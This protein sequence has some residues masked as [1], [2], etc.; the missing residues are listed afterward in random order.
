M[1]RSYGYAPNQ[2]YGWDTTSPD[3]H[4]HISRIEKM[5]S[6]LTDVPQYPQY[7]NV[8]KAFKNNY[9]SGEE[10]QQQPPKS[11]KSSPKANKKVQLSDHAEIVESNIS[12]ENCEVQKETIDTEAD[13][14]IQKKR[15][16]F[17]LCK[18]KSFKLH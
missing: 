13:G 4:A 17:E 16:G 6:V 14:F 11:K 15:K 5:P 2:Q 3:Y 8:H 10:E 12:D 1:Q 7:P 9:P 18:W